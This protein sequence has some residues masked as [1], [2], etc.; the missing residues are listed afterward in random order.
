MN[1][2]NQKKD[3]KDLLAGFKPQPG[4]KMPVTRREFV[5][6]GLI[7]GTGYMFLPSLLDAI[8]NGSIARAAEC[9]TGSAAGGLTLPAHVTVG[10]SGGACFAWDFIPGD[11]GGN[12]LNGYTTIGLP[13]NSLLASPFANTNLRIST[14]GTMVPAIL[15]AA[16]AAVCA[17]TTVIP[18]AVKSSD[19]NNTDKLDISASLVNVGLVSKVKVMGNQ[20]TATGVS[21]SDGMGLSPV[22]PFVPRSVNDVVGALGSPAVGAFAALPMV[23]RDRVMR[24]ISNISKDEASRLMQASTGKQAADLLDCAHTQNI[25]LATAPAKG[26]PRIDTR[27]NTI[28]GLTAVSNDSNTVEAAMVLAALNGDS[29]PIGINRGGFDYHNQGQTVQNNKH[30]ELGTLIGRILASAAAIGKDVV[31]SLITDG[32][33]SAGGDLAPGGDSGNRGMRVQFH[34]KAAGNLPNVKALNSMI[35]YFNASQQNDPGSPTRDNETRGAISALL[36]Y[37][38]FAGQLGMLNTAFPGNQLSTTD[39]ST[40]T[41]LG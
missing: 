26:D 13:N 40:L 19:D 1:S 39:I 6:Q 24:M 11:A 32:A 41:A 7:A 8:L 14:T 29:G 4:H 21:F 20:S 25:T 27:V 16:G 34:F 31:I 35:G 18:I 17:R 37:L 36:N 9:A 5:A 23:Q 22:T 30:V 2:K 12:F 28:W 38:Q 33:T 15:A 10:A 3:I